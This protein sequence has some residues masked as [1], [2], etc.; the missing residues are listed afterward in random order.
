MPERIVIRKPSIT[1]SLLWEYDLSA[2]DF[3]RSARVV[4]E[5]VI[6]RGNL[7]D[8]KEILRFYGEEKILE[9]ARSSRQLCEKDKHFAEIF[10]HSNLLHAA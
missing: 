4:V 2:F 3:K 8:W 1:P 5:R 6:E 9:I 7:G 10:I